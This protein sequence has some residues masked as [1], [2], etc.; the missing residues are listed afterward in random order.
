M[1]LRIY[2]SLYYLYRGRTSL[3]ARVGLAQ[4]LY[5]RLHFIVSQNMCEAG[6]FFLGCVYFFLYLHFECFSMLSLNYLCR[7]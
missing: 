6:H 1:Y 3:P 7:M 2:L 4:V 5:S